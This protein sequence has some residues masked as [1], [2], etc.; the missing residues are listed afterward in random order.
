MYGD[1]FVEREVKEDV[2]LEVISEVE[3]LKT[4]KIKP[5]SKNDLNSFFKNLD[6]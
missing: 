3:K 1:E 6:K 2:I 5:M 4:Q